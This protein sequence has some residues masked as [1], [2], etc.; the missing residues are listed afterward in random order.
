MRVVVLGGTGFVGRHVVSRLIDDGD[1]VLVV[2]R[3]GTEPPDLPAVPHLHADRASFASVAGAV[4]VF[5]PDAVVDGRA[6]SRADVE[7]VHPHLAPDVHLVEL[8]SQDVYRAYELVRAGEEGEPLPVDEES[9]VRLGRYPYR[10]LGMDEDDY[11]KLDVEPA[12][13][14]RGGTVLRLAMV[15]GEHDGQRREEFVLRRVRAGR[16]RIPVGSGSLLWTRVYA[17]DVAAAVALTLRSEAAR[18]VVLNLGEDRTRSVVGWVRQILAAAGSDAELV[19][20]PD[21]LVPVDLRLTRGRAQHLLTDSRRARDLLGWRPADAD[22]AVRRSVRWHLTHPPA[23]PDPDFTP[24]DT[25]LA[26]GAALSGG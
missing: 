7:A 12:T 16:A 18:G 15:F 1:E 3:G 22:D 21:A 24:D 6:F 23:D 26:A 13:L 5:R 17:P 14:A 20:V 25:A 4:R 19:T 10:G 2:H 11:D 8:S 9:A